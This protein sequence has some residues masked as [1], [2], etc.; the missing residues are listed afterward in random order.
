MVPQYDIIVEFDIFLLPV[1]LQNFNILFC[2]KI[3]I[4]MSPNANIRLYL[5]YKGLSY[6]ILFQKILK[7][8][9]I[10]FLCQYMQ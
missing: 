2:R 7:K 3:F 10:N 6:N 1:N 4:K 9:I 5:V 8:K